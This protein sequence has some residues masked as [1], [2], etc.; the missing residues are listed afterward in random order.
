M[1]Y[2]ILFSPNTIYAIKSSRQWQTTCEDVSA[3][4]WSS[5]DPC[6]LG[7]ILSLSD[8]HLDALCQRLILQQDEELAQSPRHTHRAFPVTQRFLR[9]HTLRVGWMGRQRDKDKC[10]RFNE[11]GKNVFFH[12]ADVPFILW[13]AGNEMKPR[14]E[15]QRMKQIQAVKQLKPMLVAESTEA[16]LLSESI[17]RIPLRRTSCE[18]QEQVRVSWS[19]LFSSS[20][21]NIKV[22]S[23]LFMRLVGLICLR[24]SVCWIWITSRT[25]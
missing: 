9:T 19:I 21:G 1:G 22:W 18:S 25:T 17:S 8:H 16:L 13:E 6:E 11:R 4:T 2:F 20:E 5:W 10:E 7:Q 24:S 23:V 15:T 3:F 14:R 12:P